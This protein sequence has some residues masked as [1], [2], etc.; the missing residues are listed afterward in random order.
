MQQ[1]GAQMVQI[2]GTFGVS[3]TTSIPYQ[4]AAAGGP[5][6]GLLQEDGTSF[7]LAE[8]GD[9]LVQE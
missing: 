8:N 2:L 4:A 3:I 1:Y 9:Y 5:T 6:N 7:I